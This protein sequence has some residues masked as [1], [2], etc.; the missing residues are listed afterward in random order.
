VREKPGFGRMPEMDE[1]TGHPAWGS[2]LR[3][4]RIRGQGCCYALLAESGKGR[5]LDWDN[6]PGFDEVNADV[7]SISRAFM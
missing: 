4:A 1:R 2:A 5:Q 6:E 7:P 3:L